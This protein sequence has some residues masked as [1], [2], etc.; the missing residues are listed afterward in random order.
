MQLRDNTNIWLQEAKLRIFLKNSL[1][2]VVLNDI[3]LRGDTYSL[4]QYS[5]KTMK[6]T[7]KATKMPIATI[8]VN[9][10]I[11]DHTDFG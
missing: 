9:S 7:N 6:P 10:P 8:R 1:V 5:I 2:S 3:D 4:D 11:R